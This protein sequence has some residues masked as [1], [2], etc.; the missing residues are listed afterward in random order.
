M[1]IHILA[2]NQHKPTLKMRFLVTLAFLLAV[3]SLAKS[4]SCAAQTESQKCLD[5]F[6]DW[7]FIIHYNCE[8]NCKFCD[9]CAELG[10]GDKCDLCKQYCKEGP[11]KCLELCNEGKKKCCNHSEA[12]ECDPE[13]L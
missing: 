7:K 1:G 6:D 4:D 2:V 11:I 12:Q 9:S 10:E 8:D 5:A 3:A 13:K